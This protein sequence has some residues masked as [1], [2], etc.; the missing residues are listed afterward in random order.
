MELSI[1]KRLRVIRSASLTKRSL[2]KRVINITLTLN[3]TVCPPA[4]L[5]DLL[6]EKKKELF[7][8]YQI[9]NNILKRWLSFRFHW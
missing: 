9:V 2:I 7:N 8:N 1:M 3:L 6:F 4:N 5:P